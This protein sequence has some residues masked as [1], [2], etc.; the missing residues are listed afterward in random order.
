M[1]VIF[2]MVTFWIKIALD[3]QFKKMKSQMLCVLF[4]LR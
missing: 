4:I 1:E 3:I 2:S